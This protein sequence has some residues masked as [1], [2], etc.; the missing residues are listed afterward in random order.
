MKIAASF[1][2]PITPQS[3][4][5]GDAS[6]VDTNS[7]RASDTTRE[8]FAELVDDNLSVPVTAVV[9][10]AETQQKFAPLYQLLSERVDL[11]AL[12]DENLPLAN[13]RAL[14]SYQTVANNAPPFGTGIAHL[15]I[16]V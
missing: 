10:L 8:V 4:L 3:R 16:I 6:K 9:E 13:Q 1:L 14:A 12:R 7:E 15:D 2:P 5:G 11:R